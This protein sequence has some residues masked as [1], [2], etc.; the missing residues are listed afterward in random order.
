MLSEKNQKNLQ[1]LKHAKERAV[2]LYFRSMIELQSS[3]SGPQVYA[4]QLGQSNALKGREIEIVSAITFYYIID[5]KSVQQFSEKLLPT[6]YL[7][8]L[9]T[10]LR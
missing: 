7:I 3:L 6:Y 10:I 8:F 5:E 1:R 4:C 2:L 9:E